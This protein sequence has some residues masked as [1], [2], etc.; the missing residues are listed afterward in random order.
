MLV[1]GNLVNIILMMT[2]RLSKR[3]KSIIGLS[4][5]SIIASTAANL[6]SHYAPEPL[7]IM[8]HTLFKTAYILSMLI[9][10]Q[11]DILRAFSSLFN[12]VEVRIFDQLNY[13]LTKISLAI[14]KSLYNAVEVHIFDQLNYA[15]ARITITAS[16]IWRRVQTGNLNLNMLLI[17]AFFLLCLF[18]LIL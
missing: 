11:T 18:I 17:L 8:N 5:T 4:S 12:A 6:Y 9:L 7:H 10:V 3:V 15:F 1:I 14:A 13:I 2:K 16:K